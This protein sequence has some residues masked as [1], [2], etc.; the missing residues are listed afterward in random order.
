MS[1]VKRISD[2]YIRNKMKKNRILLDLAE[3]KVLLN[4]EDKSQ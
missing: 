3:K 1:P 2:N 4:M